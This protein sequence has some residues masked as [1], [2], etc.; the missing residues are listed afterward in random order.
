MPRMTEKE[1]AEFERR[2]RAELEFYGD[3]RA[4]ALGFQVALVA[5]VR[6][7]RSLLCVAHEAAAMQGRPYEHPEFVEVMTEVFAIRA[8]R[9]G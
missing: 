6:R 4:F 1:L 5:E 3:E 2:C 7:L 8:E 9:E